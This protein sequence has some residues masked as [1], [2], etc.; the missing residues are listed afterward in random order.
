MDEGSGGLATRQNIM[1]RSTDGG[2][3][4]T[5]STMGARFNAVGDGVCASNSYFAK[6]NPIWRH[7]GWGEPGVGPNGVVHYAYAGQGQAQSDNGDIYYVRSTDNGVDLVGSHQTER[8]HRRPVQDAVD[9][10]ALRQLQP[11][12]L[13][14]GQQGYGLLV[15]PSP[16]HLGLQR[17]HR[18]GM[19]LRALWRSVA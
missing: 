18:S 13:P 5:S 2:V 7:M 6:V 15:R 16:G 10:F 19:Q 12:E 4:W 11:G 3:T 9:A 14:A 8:R 17:C 1:Y